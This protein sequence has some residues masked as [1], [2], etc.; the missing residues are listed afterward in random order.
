MFI[1]LTLFGFIGILNTA[2]DWGAFWLIGVLWPGAAAFVWFAK[3]A[4]YSIGVLSSFVLNSSLTFRRE[5]TAFQAKRGNSHL[6]VMGRFLAVAL[7]G[8][9]LNSFTYVLLARDAYMDRLALVIATGVSFGA[10]FVLNHCWTYKP[11]VASS[12]TS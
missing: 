9:V 10:G 6:S 4:S 7:L 3:A 1:K 5:Y 2:V 8:V 11:T 12:P